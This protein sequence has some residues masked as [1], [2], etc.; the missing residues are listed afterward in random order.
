MRPSFT[1]SRWQYEASFCPQSPCLY[2]SRGR[3]GLASEE[4]CEKV[5]R[6]RAHRGGGDQLRQ[7]R[8][9]AAKGS[10]PSQI[11]LSAGRCPREVSFCKTRAEESSSGKL[12]PRTHCRLVRWESPAVSRIMGNAATAKKGNELESGKRLIHLI[13][14]GMLYFQKSFLFL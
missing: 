1:S 2:H 4:R 12:P 10:V 13:Y 14:Y 6:L 11:P 9:T 5:K 8:R 3:L 7:E